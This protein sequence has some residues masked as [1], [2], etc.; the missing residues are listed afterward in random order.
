MPNGRE[1]AHTYDEAKRKRSN[2]IYR[3]QTN[4]EGGY[5]SID[6]TE[7]ELKKQREEEEKHSRS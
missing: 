6:V 4:D 1:N 7:R 2:Q 5:N 3:R